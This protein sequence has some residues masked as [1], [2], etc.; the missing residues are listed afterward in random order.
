MSSNDLTD[1]QE[2]IQNKA[3]EY[4]KRHKKDIAKQFTDQERFPPEEYPVSV[5][6][7]GSPGAGKTETSK[8]LIETLDGQPIMRIDPDEMRDYFE[9][10]DG[11][12]AWL[13]QGAVSVL[14]NR[15]HDMA[16]KQKQSFLL[17]GTLTNFE[18]A[19][20]NI[21]R[22]ISKDRAVQILYVYQEPALAWEFVEARE[23]EE[24]RRIQPETFLDQYF[25]ARDVVN[26][27]KRDFGKDVRVDLLC[28]NS[29]HSSKFFKAGVD[30]IDNHIPEKYTRADLE[31][32]LGL[33]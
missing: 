10:Y 14:V 13:F 19:K 30:R 12:N 6:M 32:L 29:D 17:D 2:R 3:F 31:R 22:S 23:A 25:A 18:Q 8:A 20:K 4:A 24:G 27:L 21:E 1:E 33:R 7:A 16:L 26:Q 9:D 5:F 15:I 28:K 11:T